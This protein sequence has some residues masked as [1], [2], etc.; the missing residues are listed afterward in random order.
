MWYPSSECCGGEWWVDYNS[1]FEVASGDDVRVDGT[2]VEWERT[3]SMDEMLP[4]PMLAFPTGTPPEPRLPTV[5]VG[6][7]VAGDESS[8]GER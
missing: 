5:S 6:R 8:P 4:V 2:E 1:F 7:V 3:V